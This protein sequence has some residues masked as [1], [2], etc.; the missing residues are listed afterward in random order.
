MDMK[1]P[2]VTAC[3]LLCALIF[4]APGFLSEPPGD[5]QIMARTSDTREWQGPTLYA[6][7]AAKVGTDA[8]RL[9]PGMEIISV[10]GLRILAPKGLRVRK[11]G[12][13]IQYEDTGEYLARRF[14]EHDQ[15]IA[16]VQ[17]QV[18]ELTQE[19]REAT[20]VLNAQRSK[21]GMDIQ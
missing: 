8:Q 13:H 11:E 6:P 17:S 7:T 14:D 9:R 2:V 16:A 20:S 18:N 15:A 5:D 10:D 21:K 12:S 3:L 4:P 19:L 1:V